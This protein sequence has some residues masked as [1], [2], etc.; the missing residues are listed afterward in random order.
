MKKKSLS[1]ALSCAKSRT[2]QM[3]FSVLKHILL[4][5]CTLCPWSLLAVHTFIPF[6]P[7]P[8]KVDK[9]GVPT[10]AQ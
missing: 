4:E 1:H 5:K 10:V 2:G 8:L 3:Q 6:L 9:E 7:T